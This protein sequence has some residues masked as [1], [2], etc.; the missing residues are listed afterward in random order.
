MESIIEYFAMGGYAGYVWP[1]YGVTAVILVIMLVASRRML[2]ANQAIYE[3]LAG[4]EK[5]GT[6][7]KKT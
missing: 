3:T 7:E 1:A 5:D 2:R 6:V 4:S